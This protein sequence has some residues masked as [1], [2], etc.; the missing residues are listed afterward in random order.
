MFLA[1]KKSRGCFLEVIFCGDSESNVKQMIY[2]LMMG[3]FGSF[4]LMRVS[5]P[6][7]TEIKI[8]IYKLRYFIVK[9]QYFWKIE[10]CL[11]SKT[12][13]IAYQK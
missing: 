12:A 9:Y 7:L 10:I 11:M 2:E 1:I 4:K 13:Q 8:I 5:F 3:Y 6:Y